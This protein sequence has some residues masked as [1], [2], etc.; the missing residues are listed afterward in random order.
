LLAI[1]VAIIG[2]ISGAASCGIII[3]NPAMLERIGSCRTVI[4][5]KTGTLTYGR[6]ALTEILCAR[7]VD[8]KRVLEMAL[9]SNNTRSIH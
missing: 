6:P 1:Q 8:R 7:N 3:K 5:D 4:F 9:V 2:A